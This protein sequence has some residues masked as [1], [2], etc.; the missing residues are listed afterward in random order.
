[1]FAGSGGYESPEIFVD[2]LVPATSIGALV[3]A[4][5]AVF[6]LT[7]RRRRRP[8]PKEPPVE[9]AACC[10]RYCPGAAH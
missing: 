6:A 3:V 1:V 9:L 2:G 10:A 7:I 5:G 4:G 8:E